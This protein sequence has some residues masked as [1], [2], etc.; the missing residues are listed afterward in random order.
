MKHK[1]MRIVLVAMGLITLNMSF[2]F[3]QTVTRLFDATSVELSDVASG[4]NQPYGID[5]VDKAV[6]IADT[7]N[8]MIKKLSDGEVT[9]VAGSYS[10]K[11][12]MGFPMGGLIDGHALE[13]SFNKP[14]DVIVTDDGTIYVADTG[15]NVIRKI[16]SGLVSTISGNGSE[17]NGTGAPQ[18]TSYHL[19]TA[20]ALDSNENLYVADTLN[21]AIKVISP[22]GNSTVLTFESAEDSETIALNEPSDL[23]FDTKGDLYIL[24][25]GN[26]CIRKISDGVINTVAGL[27][28]A[29]RDANG[30]TLQGYRDTTAAMAL[31]NFP[32]GMAMD[33][34][35]NLFIA[36]TWNNMIRVLLVDGN[37][38]TL[39]GDLYAGNV[40]GNI[41]LARYDAPVALDV[42]ANMLYVS[43][44]WNNEIKQIALNMSTDALK[45]STTYLKQQMKDS[46][47][48]LLSKTP[49]IYYQ[50]VGSKSDHSIFQLEN[51]TYLPLKS[52]AF[53]LGY[54][55]RWNSQLHAVEL[56]K[57]SQRLLV[58]ETTNLLLID[59]K[60]YL[61]PEALDGLFQVTVQYDA[62]LNSIFILD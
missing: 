8:N 4:L 7:Y 6:Y 56:E 45:L 20:L 61:T 28:S 13:A 36:D 5:V 59:G 39:S 23:W 19:P 24:D 37:V 33:E 17:G 48:D 34:R 54:E 26:Q 31:F 51:R 41:A 58:D 50:G 12:S 47:D 10:G 44:R 21:N 43:D 25:S 42:E 60:S 18:N 29:A 15:N 30:Y 1:M 14:R 22:N 11:N 32:K 27:S 62:A 35:G 38:K 3:G 9:V 52:F 53:A 40:V 57:E 2:A 46:Q 55:V 49:T 16:E